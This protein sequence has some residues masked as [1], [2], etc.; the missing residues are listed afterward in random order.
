MYVP[1]KDFSSASVSDQASQPYKRIDST[2]AVKNFFFSKVEDMQKCGVV[3]QVDC[4]SCDSTYIGETGRKLETRIKE[5]RSEA[6]KVTARRKTRS[7]SISE[8]PTNFKSAI[9]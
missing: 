7:T 6:E 9:S 1:S 2:V 8:D 5:H 4:L 3:Y